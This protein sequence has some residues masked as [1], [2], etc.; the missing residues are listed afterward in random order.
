MGNPDSGGKYLL[1]PLGWDGILGPGKAEPLA[2]EGVQRPLVGARLQP[3]PALMILG[4]TPCPT[5][6]RG[7]ERLLQW[8]KAR[9]LQSHMHTLT[10]HGAPDTPTRRPKINLNSSRTCFGCSSHPP[11]QS[12]IL[13][14]PISA[15]IGS[16]GSPPYGFLCLQH[17]LLLFFLALLSPLASGCLPHIES[18]TSY[19]KA[20]PEISQMK[21]YH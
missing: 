13:N 6:G 15:E 17:T 3:G 18:V 20:D 8:L 4:D 2:F 1:P 7:G 5:C 11:P 10:A 9:P 16:L 12:K 14:L 21:S 19:A